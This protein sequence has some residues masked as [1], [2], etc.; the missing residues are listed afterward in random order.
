VITVEND[1]EEIA[2][3]E[4]AIS[5][6][7]EMYA[8]TYATAFYV[9]GENS[10][11]CLMGSGTFVNLNGEKHILTA[12]HVADELEKHTDVGITIYGNG[13]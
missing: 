7:V 1:P 12:S 8:R 9:A 3:I 6:D 11:F 2:K 4:A 10:Y 5:S 13:K